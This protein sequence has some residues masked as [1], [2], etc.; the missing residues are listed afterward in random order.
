MDFLKL[1]E[2]T[3]NNKTSS[4]FSVVYELPIPSEGFEIVPSNYTTEEGDVVDMVTVGMTLTNGATFEL[5]IYSLENGATFTF[6][7]TP[8]TVGEY[9]HYIKPMS[10]KLSFRVTNWP[11][12]VTSEIFFTP[13]YLF[14]DPSHYLILDID[15][16]FS[17]PTGLY[18]VD[19]PDSVTFTV[20]LDLQVFE[21]V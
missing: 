2:A 5:F 16:N 21:G 15:Y 18:I 10:A 1:Y 7:G 3:S 17:G 20:L 19:S 4:D 14:Q 13:E 11:F 8:Y 9:K 12:A 6:P